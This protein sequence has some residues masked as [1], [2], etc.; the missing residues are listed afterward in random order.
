VNCCGYVAVSLCRRAAAAIAKT[1]FRHRVQIAFQRADI[2][3]QLLE[4]LQRELLGNAGHHPIAAPHRALAGIALVGLEGGIH[5]VCML[6]RHLGIGG[7]MGLAKPSPWQEKQALLDQRATAGA[8]SCALAALAEP[9]AGASD[10]HRS[11]HIGHV[12]LGQRIGN[13]AHGGVAAVAFL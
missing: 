4:L 11:G 10:R 6:A 3:R 7:S 5:I 9:A 13:A 2:A 12:L 8:G 1:R